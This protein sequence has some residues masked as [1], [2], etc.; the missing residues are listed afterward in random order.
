M[1]NPGWRPP[2]VAKSILL[3][4]VALM[5]AGLIAIAIQGSR[6][7]GS[8][9]P[10]DIATEHGRTSENIANLRSALLQSQAAEDEIGERLDQAMLDQNEGQKEHDTELYKEAISRTDQL[11]QA[12][13]TEDVIAE[14]P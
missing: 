12:L 6:P 1:S 7:R 13:F 3:F 8:S 11:A 2:T 14:V 9:P 10:S 4:V 5:A